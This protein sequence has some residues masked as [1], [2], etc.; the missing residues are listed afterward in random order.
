ML[1][2]R[3]LASEI[4]INKRINYNAVHGSVVYHGVTNGRRGGSSL[5]LRSWMWAGDVRDLHESLLGGEFCVV[6]HSWQ[7]S[8]A[9]VGWVA[10]ISYALLVVA[11]DSRQDLLHS[12]RM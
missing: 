11:S 12:S 6:I 3:P 4:I 1:V 7:A 2:L 10:S 8:T 9:R 5:D